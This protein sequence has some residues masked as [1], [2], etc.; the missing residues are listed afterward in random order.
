[1]N[2]AFQL[3]VLTEANNKYELYIIFMANSHT[4]KSSTTDYDMD[5]AHVSQ[6]VKV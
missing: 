5:S 1:M 3:I 4:C 6:T 2:N